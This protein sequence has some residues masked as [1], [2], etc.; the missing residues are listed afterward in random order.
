MKMKK[1]NA[2]QCFVQAFNALVLKMFI[3]WFCVKWN[4]EETVN[5]MK[6]VKWNGYAD[7]S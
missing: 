5:V 7:S 3:W 4:S 1:E 2:V 6:C